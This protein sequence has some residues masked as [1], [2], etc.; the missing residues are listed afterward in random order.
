[1]AG[2]EL[3]RREILKAGAAVTLSL[4][5]S[6]ILASGANAAG[7][8]DALKSGGYIDAVTEYIMRFDDDVADIDADAKSQAAVHG[9]VRRQ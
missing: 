8:G 3:S 7:F 1:M 4:A 6:E 5:M 2:I 9:I